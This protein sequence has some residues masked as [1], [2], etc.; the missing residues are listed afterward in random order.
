MLSGSGGIESSLMMIVVKV[1]TNTIK[2]RLIC[3]NHQRRQIGN[4]FFYKDRSP[5]HY[6]GHLLSVRDRSGQPG[7]VQ[8]DGQ[9][10]AGDDGGARRGY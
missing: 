5:S 9:Q 8:D 10:E 6:T 2:T 3:G 7:G 1:A 4:L